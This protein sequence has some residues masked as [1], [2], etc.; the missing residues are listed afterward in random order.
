MLKILLLTILLF[1]SNIILAQS[2]GNVTN[3]LKNTQLP[4]TTQGKAGT[5]VAS[6]SAA[7]QKFRNFQAVAQVITPQLQ[8]AVSPVL[9][10]VGFSFGLMQYESPL[11]RLCDVLINIDGANTQGIIQQS[12][13]YGNELSGNKFDTELDVVDKTFNVANSVYDFTNGTTRQG[14]MTSASTH[15]RLVELADSGT[16]YY[17]RRFTA[18]GSNKGL[19]TKAERRSQLDEV[20]RLAYQRSLISEATRCPSPRGNKDLLKIHSDYILPREQIIRDEEQNVF[21]YYDTLVRMGQ[22]INVEVVDYKV[23][24][25]QLNNILRS[26]FNYSVTTGFFE[27]TDSQLSGGTDADGKPKRKDTKVRRRVNLHKPV[28][29]DLIF[30]QWRN[31]NL[32]KWKSWVQGQM[33]SSG[34]FGLLDGKQGRIE[35]KYKSY[36]FECSEKN[37]ASQI[38]ISRGDPQY[39]MRMQDQRQRCQNNLKVRNNDFENL[40]DQYAQLLILSLRNKK[41]AETDI[42]NFEA[43]N[44]GYN[45]EVRNVA[46]ENDPKNFQRTDVVCSEK[47]EPAELTKLAL[48][49]NE[50]NVALKETWAK[51]E[52]KESLQIQEEMKAQYESLSKA[53]KDGRS[54]MDSQKDKQETKN[55]G[56]VIESQT[57]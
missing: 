37:L 49:N 4:P 45:R 25:A 47:L 23:Y 43:L 10:F 27:E 18:E 54:L 41:I 9:P 36:V 32:K 7:C 24:M 46:S 5:T 14:S 13:A 53:D 1:H 40:F 12:M 6:L 34:T 17:N 51:E 44:L 42:W 33:L 39:Q 3:L 20:A 21:F 31:P 2:A 38:G 29:N 22:D 16:K 35:A 11:I 48:K 57:F 55:P 50:V 15:Q 19:E 30:S 28:L 26:G 52:T 8:K 56:I